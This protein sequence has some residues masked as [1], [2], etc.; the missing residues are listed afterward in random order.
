MLKNN[1]QNSSADLS[2][3]KDFCEKNWSKVDWNIWTTSSKNDMPI[4]SP[5]LENF[6]SFYKK[7]QMN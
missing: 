7:S 5:D 6:K 3:L 4:S 2:K 1:T